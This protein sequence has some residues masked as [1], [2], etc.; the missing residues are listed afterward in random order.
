VQAYQLGAEVS[1]F[2][3]DD[4]QMEKYDIRLQDNP[5]LFD[6]NVE[7]RVKDFINAAINQVN[8]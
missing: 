1:C 5:S 6:Y 4:L 3:S 8:S 2:M 7:Q